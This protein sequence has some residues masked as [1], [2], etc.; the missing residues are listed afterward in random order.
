MNPHPGLPTPATTYPDAATEPRLRLVPTEAQLLEHY[1]FVR[2]LARALV[3]DRDVADDVAQDAMLAALRRPPQLTEGPR[4]WF[5]GVVRN[6]VKLH[7]RT[8]TRRERREHHA[9]RPDSAGSDDDTLA[10]QEIRRSVAR[11]VLALDEPYR[12]ALIHRYFEELT[13]MEIALRTGTSIETIYTRLRRGLALLRSR[14]DAGHGGERRQWWLAMIPI[15]GIPRAELALGRSASATVKMSVAA[16]VLGTL[17]VVTTLSLDRGPVPPSNELASVTPVERSGTTET[18]IDDVAEG[19]PASTATEHAGEAS[20]VAPLPALR[21][22]VVASDGSPVGAARIIASSSHGETRRTTDAAGAFELEGSPVRT[23][24]ATHPDFVATSLDV[25]EDYDPRD[26]IEIE[27]GTGPTTVIRV[28]DAE[29]GAPIAG[30]RLLV[31]AAHDDDGEVHLNSAL[32]RE[33]PDPR[34]LAEH[35]TFTSALPAFPMEWRQV[36]STLAPTFHDEAA[37]CDASGH[38]VLAPQPSGTLD[39]IGRA[40]GYELAAFTGMRVGADTVVELHR[41]GEL[42]IVSPDLE[43][44]DRITI[45]ITRR[46]IPVPVFISSI[47]PGETLTASNLPAGSYLLT[48]VM[49]A[50]V[51]SPAEPPTAPIIFC[52]TVTVERTAVTTLELFTDDG[53]DLTVHLEDEPAAEQLSLLLFA[54]DED[55]LRPRAAAV[56]DAAGSFSF[57]SVE[58]ARYTLQV[59][60]ADGP[61]LERPVDLSG[62]SMERELTVTVPAAEIAGRVFG[63]DGSPARAQLLIEPEI[64]TLTSQ[65]MP[66]LPSVTDSDGAFRLAGVKPGKRV[67]WCAIGDALLRREVEVRHGRTH[68]IDFDFR[69]ET[70]WP[71]TVELT[72]SAGDPAP[73]ILFIITPSGGATPFE[74][75]NA[76]MGLTGPGVP[77]TRHEFHLPEGAYLFGAYPMG[78]VFSWS[79]PIEVTAPLHRNFVLE[80]GVRATLVL[81]DETGSPIENTTVQLLAGAEDASVQSFQLPELP[82]RSDAAGRVTLPPLVPGRYTVTTADARTATFELERESR[83]IVIDLPARKPRAPRN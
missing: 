60:A 57:H 78:G 74:L 80:R 13:P 72:S 55:P 65:A 58:R 50:A 79:K 10:T 27:L 64:S 73:G 81:R 49:H 76:T 33:Y 31:A 17:V 54:A 68:A 43:D 83:E 11:T 5:R 16:L 59:L 25:P 7:H 37:V 41:A 6:L 12:S 39:L 82:L 51:A 38:A 61:L 69:R 67:L 4:A 9:A 77:R 21:G 2:S 30:A 15:A 14:F 35:A 32:R 34:Q 22:R 8:E 42:A 20:A 26:V 66:P 40:D 24:F 45:D 46:H 62:E 29:N 44:G 48:A 75:L 47:D 70:S 28:V 1:G 3:R 56:H 71:V 18:A 53:V 23:I 52:R 63:R 19:E 36:A